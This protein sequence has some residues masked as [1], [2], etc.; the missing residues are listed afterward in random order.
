MHIPSYLSRQRMF[1][2]C[3]MQVCGVIH[4]ALLS[5]CSLVLRTTATTKS[6]NKDF[7]F[8]GGMPFGGVAELKRRKKEKEEAERAA[9]GVVEEH[10]PAETAVEQKPGQL[11]HVRLPA[12]GTCWNTKAGRRR[13]YIY[14]RLDR[15]Y[16]SLPGCVVC[17]S[18]P[19][20]T[21]FTPAL[22]ASRSAYFWR[23]ASFAVWGD[24]GMC[25]GSRVCSL[26]VWASYANPATAPPHSYLPLGHLTTRRT[27]PVLL[28][29]KED[30]LEGQ[31]GH[32]RRR[33]YLRFWRKRK[34]LPRRR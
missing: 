2:Q 29:L 33:R 12:L 13:Q 21:F 11:Q 6:C 31:P 24:D 14:W 25:L 3:G 15:L 16:L 7:L 9:A 27:F 10:K 18:P 8:A 19:T 26:C 22:C 1:H 32:S 23:L 34:R 5:S 30:D 17:W 28:F 20:A 4:G